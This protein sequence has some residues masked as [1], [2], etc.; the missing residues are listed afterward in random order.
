MTESGFSL[1]EYDVKINK[2]RGYSGQCGS[3]LETLV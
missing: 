2:G 1:L 3:G